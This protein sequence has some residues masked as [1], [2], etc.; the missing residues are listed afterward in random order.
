[1]GAVKRYAGA[2]AISA[3]MHGVVLYPEYS[4]RPFV[5][6]SAY[7]SDKYSE[8]K[9]RKEKEAIQEERKKLIAQAR[10]NLKKGTLRLG[11]FMLNA[12]HLDTREEGKPF[13]ISKA[14]QLN[15]EY[16][17]KF[18]YEIS[19]GKGIPQAAPDVFKDID[20]YGRPGG[21]M[22][23]ALIEKM[24]SC[25]QLSHLIASVV[26]DTTDKE[27]IFLRNYGANSEG[28]AHIA[29]V[30]VQ[31]SVEYD[32]LAGA[33]A[34]KRQNGEYAGYKF[35]ASELVEA[36][37]RA[38]GLAPLV[39]ENKQGQC[40]GQE[41]AAGEEGK[42][43]RSG[44]TTLS[45]EPSGFGYK[46]ASDVYGEGVPPLFA[47]NAVKRFTGAE[48]KR[49]EEALQ[50]AGSGSQGNGQASGGQERLF[51]GRTMAD[52]LKDANREATF[53]RELRGIQDWYFRSQKHRSK[54]FE[55]TV[56]ILPF[57]EWRNDILD[58][59]FSKI[60]KTRQYADL[61]KDL[62]A[63]RLLYLGQMA[64]LCEN[65][66]FYA[67]LKGKHK[68][69]EVAVEQKKRTVE[70][71]RE[72][73]EKEKM[74]QLLN[75]VRRQA[76]TGEAPELA[77][78]VGSL[79]Y[80]GPK[81]REIL[82]ALVENPE[83]GYKDP[84][85]EMLLKIRRD[86]L[87]A[88]IDRPSSRERAMR[89]A[90]T[91]PKRMQ[92]ELFRYLA[93]TVL[94]CD[95]EFCRA[96][97]AFNEVEGLKLTTLAISEE[98][99]AMGGILNIGESLIVGGYKLQLEDVDSKTQ[100]AIIRL[101]GPDIKIARRSKIHSGATEYFYFGSGF[102]VKVKRVSP[103]FTFGA[104]WADISIPSGDRAAN[105]SVLLKEVQK[106]LSRY[107]LG[108]EWEAP[109]IEYRAKKTYMYF[110][111]VTNIP[112]EV[113]QGR[114]AFLAQMQE[115]LDKTGKD[116]K[117]L[118]EFRDWIIEMRKEEISNK[119]VDEKEQIIIKELGRVRVRGYLEA[120]PVQKRK[121]ILEEHRL[122]NELMKLK[123]ESK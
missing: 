106:I 110:I 122:T 17:A 28:I 62:P 27:H 120:D 14:R 86:A 101:T 109:L 97:N 70:A 56:N 72:I 46:G 73:I 79:I 39:A 114:L 80:L 90:E 1:M 12:N 41:G 94:D 8:Y 84:K 54:Y 4:V 116:S 85:P 60:E 34:K 53:L 36:Y 44:P 35:H 47:R 88:L 91:L 76:G 103:G 3:V 83:D 9:T 32:L 63:R 66:E 51:Q 107:N 119:L 121:L 16:E 104:K 89:I 118:K 102:Y 61:Y 67:R 69:A 71:A 13:D 115:W 48:Q 31:G 5:K 113:E 64:G 40:K 24:G 18:G 100:A 50:A 77:V 33:I 29:P 10:K 105:F 11:E 59:F 99:E 98:K 78:N 108:K 22:A 30:F 45:G 21:K 57:E 117:D 58:D 111:N 42:A 96:F 2:L 92:I 23:L 49:G 112:I 19:A 95:N 6:M 65:A 15:K 93:D 123:R 25:E 43:A 37:A 87:R 26:Y 74:D 68:L 55:G 7:L 38:H 82:F 20:Y 81:V 52:M 75:Q